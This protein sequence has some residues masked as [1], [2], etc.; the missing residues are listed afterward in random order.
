[1]HAF[2]AKFHIGQLVHHKLF[3]YRGVV[4]DVD[5]SFQGSDAWYE[6][7]ARSRPPKDHPWYKVLVHDAEHETYVAERNLE[8]DASLAPIQHPRLGD[9][10]TQLEGGR[11]R[12]IAPHN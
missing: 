8:P 5:P 4:V 7:V 2:E 6:A 10:F 12:P 11:Y 3:D 1:M 9:F